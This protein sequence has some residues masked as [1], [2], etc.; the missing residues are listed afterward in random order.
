[1][2]NRLARR[3]ASGCVHVPHGQAGH[4]RVQTADL[5]VPFG[6]GH[7]VTGRRRFAARWTAFAVV[8][9]VDVGGGGSTGQCPSPQFS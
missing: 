5:R 8:G 2:T 6:R 9:G 7:G 1:M 3:R 4:P